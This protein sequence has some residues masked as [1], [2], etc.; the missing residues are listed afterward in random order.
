MPYGNYYQTPYYQSLVPQNDMSIGQNGSNPYVNNQ[1]AFASNSA[2]ARQNSQSVQTSIMWANDEKEAENALVLANNT[3]IIMLKDMRKFY[4]K[5]ADNIG[6]Q[7]MDVYKC[8]KVLNSSQEQ[9]GAVKNAENHFDVNKFATKE[10]I[11][12]LQ[13]K[14][15]D[16]KDYITR[17]ELED[18]SNGKEKEK[19]RR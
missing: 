10:D 4:I 16:S 2:T 1:Y 14:I 13:E 6:R 9:S 17:N 5:S 3:V 8:E 19:I 18:L 15:K 12:K 7:S 11:A